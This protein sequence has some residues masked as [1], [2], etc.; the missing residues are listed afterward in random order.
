MF[1]ANFIFVVSHLKIE[2]IKFRGSRAIAGLVPL[3]HH[4]FVGPNFFLLGP[5]Y[6]RVSISWI[7]DFFSLEFPG[8]NSFSRVY[9]V[10]SQFF[11]VGITWFPIFILVGIL[12]VQGFFSWVFRGSKIF[13]R[14]YHVGSKFFLVGILWVQDFFL[15]VFC[16]FKIFCTSKFFSRGYFLG[17]K[18]YDFQ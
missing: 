17:P 14:G 7:Q 5:K 8:S 13:S 3:C 1:L 6:F 18:S 4:V 10:G 2:C 15:W 12:L 16:W 9:F 11:L